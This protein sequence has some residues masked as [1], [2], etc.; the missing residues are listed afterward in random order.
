MNYKHFTYYCLVLG[1][2]ILHI[3]G[4][5]ATCKY[6]TKTP[7][8]RVNKRLHVEIESSVSSGGQGKY[9]K[10]ERFPWPPLEAALS[11]RDFRL[12]P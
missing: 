10:N 6:E 4:L 8:I 7:L 2:F 3:N 11:L 12:P 1:T 5:Y 9:M